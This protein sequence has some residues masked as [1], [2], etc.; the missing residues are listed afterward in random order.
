M[1][2]GLLTYNIARDWDLDTLLAKCTELHYEGIELRTDQKHAH[3]VEVSL[4]KADRTSVRKRVEATGVALCGLGSGCRYDNPDPAAVRKEVEH[5]KK[6]LELTGDVGAPGLK[7]F[8]N[9]FHEAE[10]IPRPKTIEQVAAALAEC[11]RVAA[12][13]GVELRL[14]MH[15]DFYRADDVLECLRLAGHPSLKLIYNSDPR[16]MVD[17]SPV[18]I[19]KKVQA[20]VT[21]IHMHELTDPRFPYRTMVNVFKRAGY[22][23]FFVAEIEGSPQPERVLRYY[24]DLW[25]AYAD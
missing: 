14:E 19:I 16:D 24:H 17:G 4:S 20:H 7:V 15:G 2:L 12:D 1:K 6:L 3:G 25:H 13:F 10:G 9:N 21:H 11:S 22:G 8:G 5:T 18:P 23:G